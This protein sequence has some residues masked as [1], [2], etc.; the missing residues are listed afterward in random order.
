ME[1]VVLHQTGVLALD[2]RCKG[3]T[4]TYSLEPV[5]HGN[6]NRTFYVP[7]ITIVDDD[8]CSRLPN[9]SKDHTDLLKPIHLTN[10]DLNDLKYATKKFEEFDEVLTKQINEPF[11]ITH[12]RWHTIVLL[13]ITSIISLGIIFYGCRW[14]GFLNVVKH[15]CC[16]CSNR[17]AENVMPQ[18]IENVIDHNIGALTR[19]ERQPEQEAHHSRSYVTT[20]LTPPYKNSNHTVILPPLQNQ[21]KV[22]RKSG[23][24]KNPSINELN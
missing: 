5:D 8:C 11:I 15:I 23:K 14:F 16:F 10:I 2:P 17:A 1:D 6:Q 18:M 24:N 4:E 3:Y 7:Q 20:T 13:A 22:E 21:T 19:E 9:F 12:H